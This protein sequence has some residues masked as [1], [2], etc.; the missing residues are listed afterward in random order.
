MLGACVYDLYK[1]R[2][3]LDFNDL[4]QIAIGFV[5]AFIVGVLV[6]RWVLAYVGQNGFA[7]FG[8]WRIIVGSLA[9]AALWL[10]F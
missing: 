1:N 2:N 9:L 8:W 5:L 7:I 4:G 10:G 6:V 3:I